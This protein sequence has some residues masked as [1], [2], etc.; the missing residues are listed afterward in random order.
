[1]LSIFRPT[2]KVKLIKDCLTFQDQNVQVLVSMKDIIDACIELVTVN[3]CIFSM[4]DDLGLRK[5]LY[6]VLN[7][8]K[9]VLL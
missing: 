1:M 9:I 2:W 7:V 4:L 8:V 3:G 5:I 6:P